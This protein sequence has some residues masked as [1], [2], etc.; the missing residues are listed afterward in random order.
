MKEIKGKG[1]K[2]WDRV[3]G[4]NFVKRRILQGES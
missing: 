4:R 1:K 2:G 3:E